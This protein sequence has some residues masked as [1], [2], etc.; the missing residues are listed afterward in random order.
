M[1][2]IG[3]SPRFSYFLNRLD[4]LGCLLLAARLSCLCYLLPNAQWINGWKTN[5]TIPPVNAWKR[6]FLQSVSAI[7]KRLNL[8]PESVFGKTFG[9]YLNLQ[10]TSIIWKKQF[11]FFSLDNWIYLWPFIFNFLSEL[12]QH[13]PRYKRVYLITHAIWHIS[14]FIMID[15]F[16]RDVIY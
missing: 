4:V 1:R 11:V 2:G 5:P 9:K 6:G 7:G 12:D 16:L 13:S 15:H 3:F 8:Q 14:I 10:P